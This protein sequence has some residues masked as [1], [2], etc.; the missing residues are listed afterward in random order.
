MAAAQVLDGANN[1]DETQSKF[2]NLRETR[3][4]LGKVKGACQSV[5]EAALS[6][7]TTHH[8]KDEGGERKPNHHIVKTS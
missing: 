7:K 1:F 6:W 2:P 8:A 5:G 3:S 4:K